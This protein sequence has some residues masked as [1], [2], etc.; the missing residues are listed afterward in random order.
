MFQYDSPII[1]ILA[2]IGDMIILNILWFVCCLPVVTFGPATAAAHYVALKFVRDEGT[3]VTGMFFKSFRQNLRQG[4]V[5]GLLML[6]AGA[7]LGV[8]L[9]LIM[10]GKVSFSPAARLAILG[11]LWLLMFLYMMVTVYV[12]AV[13]ARFDNTIKNTVVNACVM[14]VANIRSTLMMICWDVSLAVAAVVCIAF[15]PQ[16]AALCML[17][18]VPSLFIL[19]STRLRPILDQCMEARR[20]E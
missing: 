6:A 18:G 19:N 4:I 7:V 16:L 20:E 5:L 1:R 11:I 14:A 2:R 17:F 12:W 8:D 3:S 10:T 15:V 13:M 9:W